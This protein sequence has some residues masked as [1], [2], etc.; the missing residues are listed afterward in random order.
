MKV[1]P[2]EGVTPRCAICH[3]DAADGPL[4]CPACQT[5]VHAECRVGLPCPTLGCPHGP[6]GP[7]RERVVVLRP[8][9]GEVLREA[10]GGAVASVSAT[11]SRELVV[12]ALLVFVLAGAVVGVNVAGQANPGR[13]RVAQL[14]ADMRAIG[15]AAD[16]FRIAR[17]RWPRDVEQLVEQ[18]FL[19]EL[20][21]DPWGEPYG[22][23]TSGPGC[24]VLSG[25][26]DEVIGSGDDISSVSFD[27]PSE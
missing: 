14:R 20:P 24:E 7:V 4:L 11:V 5:V 9:V 16:L 8:T 6:R 15:A 2:R 13:A 17:G 10:V 23:R 26:R 19:A 27:Y 22:L 12:A 3:D 1:A 25:G 21:L 18:G